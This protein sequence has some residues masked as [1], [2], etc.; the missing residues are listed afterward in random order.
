[1]NEWLRFREKEELDA[2]HYN[3]KNLGVGLWIYLYDVGLVSLTNVLLIEP[4]RILII[5]STAK[6]SENGNFIFMIFIE[7]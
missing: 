6:A 1:M 5:L 7:E 2:K 4:V 3:I